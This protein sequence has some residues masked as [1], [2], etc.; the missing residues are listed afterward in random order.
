M[1]SM[2]A[3]P[4]A[5]RN[6]KQRMRQHC[7]MSPFL[8]AEQHVALEGVELCHH[9]L[10][11]RS[12]HLSPRRAAS[13]S[14]IQCREPVVSASLRFASRSAESPSFGPRPFTAELPPTFSAQRRGKHG[15]FPVQRRLTLSRNGPFLAAPGKHG[16]FEVRTIDSVAVASRFRSATLAPGVR[17]RRLGWKGR[18]P[19]PGGERSLS[20]RSEKGAP[21]GPE[22]CESGQG[23]IYGGVHT[24]RT[25]R[26]ND[27][28]P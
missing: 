17:A 9:R 4:R 27:G 18:A 19:L 15:V 13:R 3:A 8:A 20:Y 6:R 11:L 23:I 14:R 2:V 10:L 24:E 26:N 22:A 1:Q 21:H 25:P 28:G 5:A 16:S 7:M 12:L